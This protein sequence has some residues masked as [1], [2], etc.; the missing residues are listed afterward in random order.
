VVQNNLPRNDAAT[1]AKG[2][3]FFWCD[4]TPL[5]DKLVGTMAR[6]SGLTLETQSS[7]Q[8]LTNGLLYINKQLIKIQRGTNILPSN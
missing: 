1:Y 5:Q 4:F 8:T 6:A 7:L 3:M 2:L